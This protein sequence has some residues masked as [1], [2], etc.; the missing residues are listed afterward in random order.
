M[1][2]RIRSPKCPQPQR[3]YPFWG[4]VT[5]G[6]FVMRQA[7]NKS[8]ESSEGSKA[9]PFIGPER[10][11]IPHGIIPTVRNIKHCCAQTYDDVVAVTLTTWTASM[12]YK[13]RCILKAFGERLTVQ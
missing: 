7:E 5:S 9:T 6:V 8:G 11:M 10:R 1:T 3:V 4:S 12:L 13:P 2:K